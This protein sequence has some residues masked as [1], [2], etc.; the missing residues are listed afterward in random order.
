[1]TFGD[2]IG[3]VDK[4]LASR[5]LEPINASANTLAAAAWTHDD[6]DLAGRPQGRCLEHLLLA[7]AFAQ[8]L[9]RFTPR[10]NAPAAFGFPLARSCL[11]SS[12]TST[13]DR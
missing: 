8:A 3:A 7:E 11:V 1:M 2:S 13:L 12:K 4:N 5:F 9:S 6:E 10:R